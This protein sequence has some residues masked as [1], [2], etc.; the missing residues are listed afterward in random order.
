MRNA[1][2]S[3]D[4]TPAR[5]VQ[6]SGKGGDWSNWRGPNYNGSTNASNLPVRFSKTE[7]VLWSTELM[8]PSHATPIVHGSRVFTTV[9]NVKQSALEVVCLDRKTGKILWSDSMGS[10]HRSGQEGSVTQLD[11]RSIYAAPSPTTDGKHVWFFFG[12]GDLACYTVSGKRVW[13]RNVQKDLHDFA[14]MWTFS[15]SPLLYKGTLYLQI[16]QRNE[17]VGRRGKQGA[18]SFILAM[19]PATGKDLWKAARPSDASN[20]SR[21]SY[22]TPMPYSNAGRDQLLI[23]GGDYV[24]G[25][26]PK[27]GKELWRWGTWNPGHRELWWRLVPSPVAGDGIVM[28]C[29]PKK[30]PVFAL[31][32]TKLGDLS[33]DGLLWKSDERSVVSSD[34]ATPAF[35]NGRFYVVSDVRKS[36]S[37]TDAK[38]GKVIWST[39]VPGFNMCWGSPTIA[40]GKLYTTSVGGVIFVFDIAT[41]RLLGEN[42]LDDEGSDVRTCVSVAGNQLFIRTSRRL[43]C[44]GNN[45]R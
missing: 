17:T 25:H 8:G 35:D 27:S 28:V 10:G 21:E 16:L 20:E 37:A 2:N 11:E 42:R 40:D 34:V 30:A 3:T 9:A 45:V 5:S 22:G 1:S 29:A 13:S 36:V 38:S 14:F 41:G 23:A 26:D 44:I 4:N 19:D 15:S 43:F 33:A 24:S 32:T 6:S 7:N 39:D 18:E 12:N 31:P